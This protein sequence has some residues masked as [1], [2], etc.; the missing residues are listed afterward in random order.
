MI[1][2]CGSLKETF[3]WT[4]IIKGAGC[5]R[6]RNL[7]VIIVVI[8]ATTISRRR[9][10]MTAAVSTGATTTTTG[11]STSSTS[12]MTT[13]TAAAGGIRVLSERQAVILDM[14]TYTGCWG[15]IIY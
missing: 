15:M 4:T 3:G 7:F 6:F 13:A 12:T 11:M 9:S 1:G 14:G 5:V 2:D 8:I 10:G